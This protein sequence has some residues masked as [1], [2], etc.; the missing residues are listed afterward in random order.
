MF[1]AIAFA[2]RLFL[3]GVK[4]L[5]LDEVLGLN[6]ALRGQALLWAGQSEGYHPPLYYLILERWQLLG[7]SELSLRMSSVIPGALAVWVGYVLGR[8][9]FGR[10]VALTATALLAFSPYLVWYSQEL[11]PYALM[12]L[13]GLVIILSATK[14]FS[15]MSWPYTLLLVV[16]TTAILYLHYFGVLFIPLQLLLFVVL[17]A[18][19]Q[20]RWQRLPVWM[21]AMGLSIAGYWPWLQS[22]NISRFLGVVLSERNYITLLLNERLGTDLQM[23]LSFVVVVMAIAAA[24]GLPIAYFSARWLFNQPQLSSLRRHPAVQVVV[25]TLFVVSL[26]VIVFPRGYTF[27]RHLVAFW[28]FTLIIL[29]WF[30]PWGQR[31]GRILAV[32]LFLSFCATVV[33]TTLIPKPQ[34]EKANARIIANQ[35]AGDLVILEPS[36]M[37]LPFDFYNQGESERLGVRFASAEIE[38]ALREHGRIWFIT[39]GADY[40]SAHQNEAWLNKNAHLVEAYQFYRLKVQ[41]FESGEVRE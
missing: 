12:T 21:V 20:T 6:V 18:A 16:S 3:V 7:H 15:E 26:V 38:T 19:G 9:W 29:A 11:R 14:L 24:I 13:L 40:D 1:V 5:W 35:Q 32:M 30:W 41:L 33:N 25:I 8:V 10:K 2:L 37:R 23:G 4:S 36:Y 17:L 39:H 31:F 34:W 22:P 28:P 27:K